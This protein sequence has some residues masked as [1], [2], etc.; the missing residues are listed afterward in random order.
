VLRGGI[1]RLAREV[2]DVKPLPPAKNRRIGFVIDD[3]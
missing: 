2:K 3:D 1:D